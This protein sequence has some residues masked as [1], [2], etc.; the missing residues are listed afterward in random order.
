MRVRHK[1]PRK[2]ILL[3]P[4]R[5]RALVLISIRDD[6]VGQTAFRRERQPYLHAFLLSVG[7]PCKKAAKGFMAAIDKP[8]K[9]V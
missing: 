8:L 9:I 7:V 1:P 4:T 3:G 6:P 2:R 5:D